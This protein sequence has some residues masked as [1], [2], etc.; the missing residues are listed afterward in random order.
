MK[1]IDVGCGPGTSKCMSNP[2]RSASSRGRASR[3]WNGIVIVAPDVVADG[4]ADP[5]AAEPYGI[6]MS[7]ITA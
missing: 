2:I 5:A 6:V 3:G 7:L 1:T 4:T